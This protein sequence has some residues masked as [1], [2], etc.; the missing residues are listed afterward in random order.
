MKPLLVMAPA[1]ARWPALADLYRHKGQPWLADIEARV[2]RGVLGAQD[3]FAIIP[4]GGHVL[5]GAALSKRGPIGVL[6]HVYTRPEHRRRGF[7]RNVV[8]TLL[9]WFDM[10][11]GRWLY[12]G[13]TAELDAS[14]YAKFGFTPLHRVAWT[15][16]DRITMQRVR[17][18][19][20]PD[21]L[22][23]ATGTVRVRPLTRADWP[24]MVALLQHRPGPDPRL[25]IAESAVSAELFTLDLIGHQERGAAQLRG[26]FFGDR[27]LG[28]GT[29]ATERPGPRTYA[30]LVP[31]QDAPPALRTALLELARERGYEQV[32]FPM[33]ALVGAGPLPP[34]GETAGPPTPAG[35]AVSAAP[36]GASSPEPTVAPSGSAAADFSI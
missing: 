1:P 11:G 12:L 23:D 15:P 14:L 22:A 2:S 16:F 18:G 32:D 17:P 8:E 34:G 35:D 4:D 5:A 3:A 19:T 24:T 20:P 26:A 33:D 13:T 29:L 10:V 31:H 7:A 9:T 25:P 30:M 21:P 27:L 6:G 28:L 36:A